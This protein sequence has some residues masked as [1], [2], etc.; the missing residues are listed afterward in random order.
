M[1]PQDVV[2]DVEGGACATIERVAVEGLR[3]KGGF[4][5]GERTNGGGGRVG[6][7]A[8]DLEGGIGD[9]TD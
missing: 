5:L 6:G 1:V 8:L 3:E 2:A 9:R 4:G 7:V